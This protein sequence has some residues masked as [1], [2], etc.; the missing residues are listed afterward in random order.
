M[1]FRQA[2]LA[3]YLECESSL[4]VAE[5]FPC[6]SSWVRSLVKSYRE[7]GSLEPK[8]LRIPDNNSLD[9]QDLSELAKIIER[10]PDL[11]LAELAQRLDSKTGTKVSVPTI[12]RARKKLG[13]SRKKSPSTPPSRSVRT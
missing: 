1:E 10:E 9:D 13:L 5:Q 8:P 6:S 12:Y 3:A 7:T 4:E 2:V 11:E